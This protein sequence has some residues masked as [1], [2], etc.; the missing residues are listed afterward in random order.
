MDNPR[1]ETPTEVADFWRKH[2]VSAPWFKDD[3]ECLCVFLLNV[4]RKLIGFELVSQGTL[5][6]ILTH[7]REVLRLAIFQNAGA[8][9]I[10]HNHPSGDPTPSS[11]DISITKRLVKAG[12]LLNIS[13]LDHV[14]L[15]HRATGREQDYVSLKELGLM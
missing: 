14:I 12:E 2:V 10:A 5:D 7:P 11:E 9:I 3:K 8:I 4:R 1:I 13:V 6:T 15:G